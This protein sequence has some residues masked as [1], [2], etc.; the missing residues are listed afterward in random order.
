[1]LQDINTD[2]DNVGDLTD[3]QSTSMHE[4]GD[5]EEVASP[6]D[7][8]DDTGIKIDAEV[9]KV[10]SAHIPILEA[11]VEPVV[12]RSSPSQPLEGDDAS[13]HSAPV[14]LGDGPESRTIQTRPSTAR[15]ISSSANSPLPSPAVSRVQRT[16]ES[17]VS[18]G[19]RVNRHRS[20]T[21]V[22]V[23]RQFIAECKN[24]SFIIRRLA[25]QIAFLD[26]SLTSSIGEMHSLPQRLEV[27]SAKNEHLPQLELTHHPPLYLEPR[28]RH[29]QDRLLRRLH[30]P[31]LLFKSSDYHSRYSH[32][33]FR[34]LTL[35][36]LLSAG[37]F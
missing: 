20:A 16:T 2:Q 19:E 17:T 21:E 33:T 25:L 31:H 24:L 37:H 35:A 5:I 12:E 3:T 36:R 34:H 9:G 23:Y 14:A 4:L 27:L 7:Q 11:T 6:T 13:T 18:A 29:L 1:M 28:P 10:D 15:T 30:S 8:E 22:C 26:F 32:R